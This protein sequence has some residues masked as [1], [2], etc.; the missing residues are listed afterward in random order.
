MCKATNLKTCVIC[1]GV[2]LATGC[3]GPGLGPARDAAN[4]RWSQTRAGVK[5]QLAADQI[6]Q[7][8]LEEAAAQLAAARELAPDD[9]APAVLDARV[10]L[11]TGDDARAER[12]LTPLK[13]EGWIGAEACYLEG[14]IWQNRREWSRAISCFQQA[15]ALDSER[16]EYPLAVVEGLLQAGRPSDALEMLESHLP[17]FGWTPAYQAM[18]AEC[19][20]ALGRWDAAAAAWS[21]VLSAAPNAGTD[22]RLGLAMHRAGQW[23]KAAAALERALEAPVAADA[24]KRVGLRLALADCLAEQGQFERARDAL[25]FVLREAPRMLN[26]QLLMIRV[27]LGLGETGRALRAAEAMTRDHPREV[28]ALEAAA[29]VCLRLGETQRARQLAE[30][31]SAIAASPISER[32]LAM[33]Q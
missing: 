5:L 33:S 4:K 8:N 22:A 14:V 32:V 13:R 24:S 16:V 29:A 31:A 7:G 27:L 23:K 3:A 12:I 11:A 15:A 28:R 6:D 26:A 25:A 1:A 18:N 21:K 17:A 30:A 20:E 2:L 9:P 19:C 10:A